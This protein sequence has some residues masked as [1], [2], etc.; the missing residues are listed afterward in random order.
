M[1]LRALLLLL[2]FVALSVAATLYFGNEVLIALGLILAQAKV[3]LKKLAGIELP[4]FILWLKTQA[5]AFFRVELLKKWLTTSAVPLV[6]GKALLRRVQR[7][8]QG[9]MG[10]VRDS[11]ARLMGWFRGLSPLERALAWLI[12]L[13]ATL[14]LSV[15]T[16]GLWL[17]LFSV[18]L[19]LWLA[20]AMGALVRMTSASVQKMAFKALA[21]FQLKW[22]WRAVRRLLPAR[23]LAWKRWAEFRIVRQV[24]RRRRMTLKQLVD[25]KGSLPFKLGLLAEYLFHPPGRR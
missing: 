6:L 3:L 5:A 10:I 13:F 2:I 22:L 11:H 23:F 1:L 20:A 14:A 9:Y 19:P 16:V 4:V 8:V 17:V 12:I 21:F 18:Q 15:T 7:L 24:V 25:R